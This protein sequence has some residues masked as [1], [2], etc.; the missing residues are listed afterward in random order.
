MRAR[1]GGRAKRIGPS[2]QNLADRGG[3]KKANSKSNPGPRF[4]AI[5]L[6]FFPRRK[7]RLDFAH[8][9]KNSFLLNSENLGRVGGGLKFIHSSLFTAQKG[10]QWP[11]GTRTSF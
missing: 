11:T 8:Q 4:G 10:R 2:Q 7:N 3:V 9:A 1:S 6:E 5:R